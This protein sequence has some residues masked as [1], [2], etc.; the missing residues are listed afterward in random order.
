MRSRDVLL[1]LS[2]VIVGCNRVV[3]EIGMIYRKDGILLITDVCDESI[4]LKGEIADS[5]VAILDYAN[6]LSHSH[7]W[8]LI[9]KLETPRRPLPLP[10]GADV[11]HDDIPDYTIYGSSSYYYT[12]FISSDV[13]ERNRVADSLCGK[14]DERSIVSISWDLAVSITGDK[15]KIIETWHAR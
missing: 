9:E 15:K 2:V 12:I 14:P 5:V 4:A 8:S 1:L 10:E 11:D 6:M 7:S 3:P 13:I